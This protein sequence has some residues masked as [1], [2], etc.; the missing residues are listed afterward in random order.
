VKDPGHRPGLLPRKEAG[1]NYVRAGAAALKPP[2]A[3]PPRSQTGASWLFPVKNQVVQ[4][5]LPSELLDTKIPYRADF[6]HE[7]RF[8]DTG[9]TEKHG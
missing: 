2:P 9:H 4:P 7:T 8:W 1:A 6:L 5:F 3:I